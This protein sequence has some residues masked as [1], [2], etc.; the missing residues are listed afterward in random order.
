MREE[1]G[2]QLDLYIF[3]LLENESDLKMFIDFEVTSTS[4]SICRTF[5]NCCPFKI[6]NV[7]YAILN[8]CSV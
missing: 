6:R 2:P 1:E 7:L 3:F 5:E 8:P 4:Y